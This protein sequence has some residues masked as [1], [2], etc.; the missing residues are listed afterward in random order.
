MLLIDRDSGAFPLIAV[1]SSTLLFRL[2]ATFLTE[3]Q[4]RPR[5]ATCGPVL[6]ASG[7]CILLI[8]LPLKTFMSAAEMPTLSTGWR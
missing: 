5:R 7:L 6:G 1:R 8:D 3:D 2:P 4:R